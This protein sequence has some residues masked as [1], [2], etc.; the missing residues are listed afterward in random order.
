[1]K[2]MGIT[3]MV[4]WMAFTALAQTH[5][6]TGTI[7]D[8]HGQPLSGAL[9]ALSGTNLGAV[10]D[11][12]GWYQLTEV[13][14]GLIKLVVSS[15]GYVNS[16][17]DLT[18][19]QNQVVD[20][21][22]ESATY[23]LELVEVTHHLAGQNTPVTYKNL[24]VS[25]L[26]KYNTGQDL[27]YLI[28]QTPSLLITSDAG[29]GVGYSGLRIRGSD[30]TRI[31]VT[32]NGVP[33]NDAESQNVFWVD[34]PDLSS[35]AQTIQIQRGVGNSQHGAGAFGATINVT[36]DYIQREPH[37]SLSTTAGSFNTFKG[38]LEAGTG[39][40]QDRFGVDVRLSRI[41]SD[42]YIDRARTD[43]NSLYISGLWLGPKQSWRM[44]VMNGSEVTYQ[45]WNGV[46][47]QYRHDPI[48]R[49]FNS[50]G[51]ER[52][53]D[54]H[55]NE[56][57]DYGQT[58]Y[59]LIHQREISTAWDLNVTAHYTRGK[60][61]FEQYKSRQTLADYSIQ[62]PDEPEATSDLIRRRWL[63]NHFY[64]VIGTLKWAS[65][66]QRFGSTW[67][68][69]WNDYHGRHFGE[70]TWAR[71]M[72]LAEQGQRYYDNDALKQDYSAYW[73]GHWNP[74]LNWS[75]FLDLQN[76]LVNYRFQ[77]IQDDGIP[78]PQRVSHH[79]FNPKAG[80][81]WRPAAGLRTYAS[82][83]VAHKEPNRDDYVASNPGSRPQAER[84]YN[85]ELGLNRERKNYFWQ[86]NAFYMHYHQQLV[87]TGQLNDVGA[88]T[89]SNVPVSHRLGIELDGSYQ[90]NERLSIRSDLTLSRHRIKQ[91]TEFIDNWDEGVQDQIVRKNAPIVLSPDF[92]AHYGLDYKLWSKQ[93]KHSLTVSWEGMGVSRQH[94]D[95]SGVRAASLPAYHVQDVFLR[96]HLHPRQARE[97]KIIFQVQ[98]VLNR[99]YASNGWVYRFRST[100]YDP[101]P[102]DPYAELEQSDVYHLAGYFNQATRH[103]IFGIELSW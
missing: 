10:S 24:D 14:P 68:L 93:D 12:R 33:L 78:A 54:P 66:D 69:A 102:D 94:L 99:R 36:T 88:Y 4:L 86:I 39:L 55:P 34:L 56:V 65:D 11:A 96:W 59:Q 44:V 27:P 85:M 70:V 31:N 52:P 101:R 16:Y 38:T 35:S 100:G 23:N 28:R 53:G 92:T 19:S 77:G 103:F 46:P 74:S 49:T 40:L 62:V 75:W 67:G 58:H 89:R 84:L 3:Y 9:I 20:I 50:A 13:P 97:L 76:R 83:G 6:I 45:A 21:I 25:A 15:L 87:P 80:V 43:L 26:D 82:I 63:D 90:L 64:G 41:G 29:N 91:F 61:F 42:G 51:T 7:T 8:Q 32:I 72:G 1:M 22:L 79:F 73:Q 30:P 95:N 47:A 18:L 81:T 60:G 98:N 5:T 37:L 71:R 2:K 48:L 17:K 57:D